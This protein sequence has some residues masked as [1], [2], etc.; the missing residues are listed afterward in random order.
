LL[1]IFIYHSEAFR[2][3]RLIF[4]WARPRFFP[5]AIRALKEIIPPCEARIFGSRQVMLTIAPRAKKTAASYRT[6][7]G[8]VFI[9]SLYNMSKNTA[10]AADSSRRSLG[11]GGPVPRTRDHRQFG[12]TPPRIP[13]RCTTS[14]SSSV[15][16]NAPLTKNSK[17]HNPLS[18]IMK[19]KI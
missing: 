17:I 14:Y 7:L 5:C 3:L 6:R 11:E 19:H 2:S 13:W 8:A 1:P 10:A 9:Y 15:Q 4:S 16:K 12:H 18:T